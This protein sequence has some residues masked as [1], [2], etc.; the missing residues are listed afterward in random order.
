MTSRSCLYYGELGNFIPHCPKRPGNVQSPLTT[1]RRVTGLFVS[2]QAPVSFCFFSAV[3]SW[4]GNFHSTAALFDF[5]ADGN[6]KTQ[7]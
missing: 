7:S 4:S 5:G 3:L 6:F 2:S 1:G